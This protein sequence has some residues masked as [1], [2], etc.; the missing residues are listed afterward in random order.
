MKAGFFNEKNYGSGLFSFV[1][2]FPD[3]K[4]VADCSQ[5]PLTS[6]TYFF[7]K[8]MLLPEYPLSFTANVPE[9]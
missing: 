6:L 8:F 5:G 3:G 1:N 4:K 2:L 7:L 9:M